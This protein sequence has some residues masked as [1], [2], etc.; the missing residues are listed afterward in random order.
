MLTGGAAAACAG[1]SGGS[2][3]RG[4]K[5]RKPATLTNANCA[6]AAVRVERPGTAD[7]MK[8]GT[9]YTT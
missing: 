8:I 4:R 5:A 3:G 9:I 1:S 7:L 6:I 2:D